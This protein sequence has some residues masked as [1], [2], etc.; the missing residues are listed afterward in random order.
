MRNKVETPKRYR[1]TGKERDEES[2]LYYHGARY[3]ATWLGRWGNCDPAGLID[4]PDLYVYV[5]AD[6]ISGKDPSGLDTV[7]LKEITIVGRTPDQ[8][9]AD[10]QSKTGMRAYDAAKALGIQPG[11]TSAW[12]SDTESAL[13][14]IGAIHPFEDPA[15]SAQQ[16]EYEGPSIG[17][18]NEPYDR[19]SRY[20]K[21]PVDDPLQYEWTRVWATPEEAD[22]MQKRVDT[23]EA[24]ARAGA[25]L[26]AAAGGG[27]GSA[28]R[29]FIQNAGP[30]SGAAFGRPRIES[31]N[32]TCA[33]PL[34]GKDRPVPNVPD[35]SSPYRP[36]SNPENA[37]RGN[38]VWTSAQ[39]L[40]E[41]IA[42]QA[43]R[44]GEGEIIMAGPFG[45][46][47]YQGQGWEKVQYKTYTADGNKIEIH[48]MR[49]TVTGQTDQFKFLSRG[50]YEKP[51]IDPKVPAGNRPF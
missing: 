9:A 11:G 2:G 13:E 15:S 25:A 37:K 42:M 6:P 35:T 40:P 14:R 41:Q 7:T 8:I 45:D 21:T 18:L 20:I 30:R 44:S 50:V 51:K 31:A 38:I 10:I 39:T 36:D 24:S 49:N 28:S 33:Y 5:K 16:Q 48:Y 46:I 3:Y 29:A 17:P 34:F 43:A 23:E 22:E 27:R 4:G 47:K 19:R 12:I 32:Q 1:Y 26:A